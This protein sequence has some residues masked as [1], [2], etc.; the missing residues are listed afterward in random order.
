M[1]HEERDPL[2]DSIY[3]REMADALAHG[4]AVAFV[5]AGI[6]QGAGL[7]T[8][9]DLLKGATDRAEETLPE[10]SA[11]IQKLRAVLSQGDLPLAAALLKR[12]Y[13]AFS[14]FVNESL[15]DPESSPSTTHYAISRLPFAQAITTNFDSLLERSY[16]PAITDSINWTDAEVI[17]TKLQRNDFCLIKLHGQ[18]SNPNRIV[19]TDD[20]IRI[21]QQRS[22]PLRKCL[23]LIFLTRQVIF[24]GHSLRDPD[25]L[26]WLSDLKAEFPNFGPHYALLPKGDITES[27]KRHVEDRLNIR[28][29]SYEHRPDQTLELTRLL[30]L[31]HG[32]VGR[33]RMNLGFPF[34]RAAGLEKTESKLSYLI[35]EAAKVIGAF[36]G[37]LCFFHDER[38]VGTDTVGRFPPSPSEATETLGTR[39]DMV[40]ESAPG[41]ESPRLQFDYSYGPTEFTITGLDTFAGHRGNHSY[42]NPVPSLVWPPSVVWTCFHLT[43]E[44]INIEDVNG[45][46][47]LHHDDV[48]YRGAHTA[49]RSEMAVPIYSGGVR[50]G[51]LNLES[52]I[53]GAFTRDHMATARIFAAEIG[54]VSEQLWRSDTYREGVIKNESLTPFRDGSAGEKTLDLESAIKAIAGCQEDVDFRLFLADYESGQ[55]RS[56]GNTKNNVTV[57]YA[58]QDR[59]FASLIFRNGRP[60]YVDNRFGKLPKWFEIN[61]SYATKESVGPQILGVPLFNRGVKVGVLV[62]WG[63]RRNGVYG[64]GEG[65]LTLA[66]ARLISYSTQLLA[67]AHYLRRITPFRLEYGLICQDMLAFLAAVDQAHRSSSKKI[68][69]ESLDELLNQIRLGVGVDRVRLLFNNLWPKTEVKLLCIGSIQGCHQGSSESSLLQP[70]APLREAFRSNSGHLRIENTDEN[71]FIQY[72][73]NRIAWSPETV[74]LYPNLLSDSGAPVTQPA[75]SRNRG[76]TQFDQAADSYARDRQVGWYVAPLTSLTQYTLAQSLDDWDIEMRQLLGLLVVD[77]TKNYRAD[78]VVISCR[79]NDFRRSRTWHELLKLKLNWYGCVLS[80]KLGQELGSLGAGVRL[81]KV[82]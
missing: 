32:R 52:N 25:L 24:L 21:V 53:I 27:Y 11:E 40:R 62:A 66:S 61:E 75:P 16:S 18:F 17:L 60:L 36:R 19:L 80:A 8:W 55:L 44:G 69:Q 37:D 34:W 22:H 59:S 3:W 15:N 57:S 41:N 38:Y 20:D 78:G 2:E 74:L 31:L 7:M 49:V 1:D 14:N 4:R 71:P 5:G 42:K 39:S 29:V 13:P 64:T 9:D 48:A 23:E 47:H 35:E 51:V 50:L 81:D 6:S 10:S 63:V 73:R 26:G 56:N 30:T 54:R 28:L 43:R 12:V 82:G 65:A 79:Q 76:D 67:R 77:N 58:F 45:P 70:D 72:L 33:L 46:R 68:S